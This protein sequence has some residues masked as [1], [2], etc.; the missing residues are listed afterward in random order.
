MAIITKQTGLEKLA[1]DIREGAELRVYRSPEEKKRLEE[2]LLEISQ[3]KLFDINE[4]LWVMLHDLV[5]KHSP[6]AAKYLRRVRHVDDRHTYVIVMRGD[7]GV[8][9]DGGDQDARMFISMHPGLLEVADVVAGSGHYTAMVNLS[10]EEELEEQ[11]E[12][13]VSGFEELWL[14]RG[15]VC[16]NQDEVLDT[17]LFWVAQTLELEHPYCGVCRECTRGVQKR[18]LPSKADML[19]LQK[20]DKKRN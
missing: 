14:L 11:V 8:L 12:F 5:A 13:L 15:P 3:G 4:G 10:M 6:S 18:P 16:P 20:E 1:H 2:K 19:R 17:D 7:F 9:T